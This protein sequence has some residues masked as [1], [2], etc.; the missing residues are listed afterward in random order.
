MNREEIY[1][2]LAQVYLGKRKEVDVKKKRQK[3]AW[4]LV[5][6]FISVL[7]FTSA[8]W[9]FTAFLTQRGT[10]LQSNVIFSLN[11]GP[12]SVDYNFKDTFSPEK[13]FSLVVPDMDVSKYQAIEFSIRGK[14]EGTPGVVKIVIANEKNETASYYVQG[15]NLKWQ[16]INIPLSEFK[17]ITDWS[18]L[19]DIS[20]VLEVWNVDDKKGIILIEDVRFSGAY[21]A[22]ASKV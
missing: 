18:S 15:V 10:S 5:N 12:I 14:E 4:L 7:I 8:I 9:G 17:Q 1:D 2:H 6:I 21:D 20:F 11:R 22:S 3:N 19:T 13:T 16:D